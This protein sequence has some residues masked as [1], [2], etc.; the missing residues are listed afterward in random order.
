MGLFFTF[1]S[2][3]QDVQ[4]KILDAVSLTPVEVVN[5]YARD[6]AGIRVVFDLHKTA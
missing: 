5:I 6:K 4:L 3:A 1:Y 2:S